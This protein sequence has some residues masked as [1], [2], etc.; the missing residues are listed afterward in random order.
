[1]DDNDK[2]ASLPIPTYEE[3]ISSRPSSSQTF[4]GAGEISDDAERQ[5][6]LETGGGEGYRQATVES[7]RSSEDSDL[8][9]PEVT[10]DGDYARRQV[11]QLDYMEPGDE[12]FS[13]QRGFY[14]RARLRSNFSK[15]LAN[16]SA[17]FSSIRLPSFRSLY[18]PVASGDGTND[19]EAPA[20]P[21]TWRS[22]FRRPRIP[23]QYQMSLP[24]LA[25]LMGLSLIAAFIY[26]LFAMDIFP[27]NGPHM[28]RH[29]NPEAVRQFVQSNVRAENI[30][31]YLEHISSF[32]HVAGTEGDYYLA[33][34]MREQ[35]LEAGGFDDV[36]LLQYFVYMNYPTK[37]GRSVK[38]LSKEG[39]EWTAQMEE[40]TVNSERKQTLAWHG[41]SQSGEAKGHLI[42]VNGGSR[43]DFKW[44]Q[45]KGVKTKGAIALVREFAAPDSL[46]LKIKAAEEA[47][48]AGTLIYSDPI[49]GEGGVWPD[50]PW[51]PEESVQRGD[52]SLTGWVIGDPLTPGYSSSRGAKRLGRPGNPGLVQIPS[53]PLAWRDAKVLLHALEG[54]GKKV[55]S[56]WIGE[57]GQGEWFTGGDGK[58]APV[59]ELRNHQDEEEQQRIWNLHAAIEGIESSG[60][61]VMVGN[62]RDAW[63]FG[64]ADPGSGTAVMMEVV[65]IFNQ[66]RKQ[67]WRPLRTIEFVSWD[68]GEFNIMGSTEYVE[69]NIEYLRKNGVAYINVAAGVT[70]PDLH[71]AASPL[72]GKTLE[73]VLKRVS[74][75]TSNSTLQ[76]IWDQKKSVLHGLDVKGDYAAFQDMAGLSSLDFG[77][78]GPEQGYPA[79]SCY[80]TFDWVQQYGDP[81]FQYHQ[82]LAQIWAL[83]ILEIADRPLVPFDLLAYADAMELYVKRLQQDAEQIYSR[84]N[85]SI[86]AAL[87]PKNLET[88]T[89]FTTAPLTSAIVQLK[90][91]F[92][93]FHRFED[94]W[95]TNVL[96]A[97]GLETTRFAIQRLDYND[98][99]A[100]F[101]TDLLDLPVDKND[102]GVHGIPGREQFKHILFGPGKWGGEG[103][104]FPAVRDALEEGEWEVA[105]GRLERAAGVMRKAGRRLLE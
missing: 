4:R 39:P 10:S 43:E 47:G 27:G 69:D 33:T 35:W 95:T 25:R 13:R 32:D 67:G 52:V 7:A 81:D 85:P 37:D 29:F 63:C 58:D 103:E 87:N 22:R 44:L 65:S 88:L 97:G 24:I 19:D 8:R 70:G 90:D 17:T 84:L 99:L 59:V 26:I 23:E 42:Y 92:R 61:K 102:K 75:P 79:H 77:F 46:A 64:A 57:K 51:Q 28:G 74:D 100:H 96:G 45:E 80:D 38:L 5:G 78:K 98:R 93:A 56:E 72:L 83:L 105:M 60:K 66:L 18:T 62:H 3:A 11:E 31:A 48:C 34:W 9:L 54:H 21:Q 2:Y 6:L 104:Q 16:I 73:H 94:L 76:E 55:P 49:E 15:R 86:S 40:E 68:A 30:A 71:A 12:T 36:A 82:T 91:N 50:G 14:H 101:E 41:H 89:N 1:M 53:L 20:E